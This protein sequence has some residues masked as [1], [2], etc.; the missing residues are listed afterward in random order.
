MYQQRPCQE[1]DI[2]EKI[3]KNKWWSKVQG[4]WTKSN[5]ERGETEWEDE[6]GMVPVL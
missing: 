2:W 1:I 5:T 4:F 6:Y 3:K